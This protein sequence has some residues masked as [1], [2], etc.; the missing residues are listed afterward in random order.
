MCQTN[1]VLN[2]NGNEKL[3][4]ENV[5]ALK[6]VEDGLLI[7]TLFEGE[8]EFSGMSLDRIDFNEGKVYLFKP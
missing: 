1:V 8:K 7:T 3:L 5:T 6:I 2:E 4:L